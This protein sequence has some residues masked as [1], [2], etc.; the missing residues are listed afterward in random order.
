LKVKVI[1]LGQRK[2]LRNTGGGIRSAQWRGSLWSYC[3]RQL[4]VAVMNIVDGAITFVASKT[5]RR[6]R[7]PL[8]IPMLPELVEAL[9][10][11]PPSKVVILRPA[12]TFL[13]TSSG[14]AFKS[15]ASFGNWFRHRSDEARLPKH[16]SAHGLRK[17]TA[18]RLAELGCSAHQIAAVTGHATLTE[19]QRYTAAADRKR[20]AQEAMSKLIQGKP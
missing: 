4:R 3:L 12:A 1:P 15:A 18:R 9:E 14:Q 6:L 20:L 7:E 13:T 2:T 10:A 16:L 11:M 5:Q 19:V 8:L 17:A